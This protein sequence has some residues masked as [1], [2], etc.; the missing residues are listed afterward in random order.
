MI[1]L[2]AKC[3]NCGAFVQMV[4]NR[5]TDSLR[6]CKCERCGEELSKQRVRRIEHHLDGLIS[7]MEGQCF[8]IKS[9]TVRLK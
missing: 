9:A 7:A 5:E 6:G 1:F 4:Y 8:D 3:K 2:D